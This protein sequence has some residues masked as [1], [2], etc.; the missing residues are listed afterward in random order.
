MST[1]GEVGHFRKAIPNRA[2]IL[3]ILA[4]A[5]VQITM[6]AIFIHEH[7][8]LPLVVRFLFILFC[9]IALSSYILL[10]GYVYRDAS[11]RGMPCVPWTLIAFLVPNGVGFVLYFVLRK[12]LLRPC[13]HCGHAIGPEHAFCPFCGGPQRN[14]EK[15]SIGR[16]S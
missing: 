2:L 9:G 1:H 4:F 8:T 7:D 14:V 6:H 3:A 16:V 12:P 10:T 11:R 5:G 15:Q 13:T